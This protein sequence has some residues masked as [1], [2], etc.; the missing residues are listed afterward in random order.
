MS[1]LLWY[2]FVY[3]KSMKQGALGPLEW[4]SSFFDVFPTEKL[5]S[6]TFITE[7]KNEYCF[8]YTK[9]ITQIVPILFLEPFSGS[10]AA[11]VAQAAQACGWMH[12]C[13]ADGSIFILQPPVSSTC[14]RWRLE[15]SAQTRHC[16]E[17]LTSYV[18]LLLQRG[19]T[20]TPQSSRGSSSSSGKEKKEKHKS[21]QEHQN[22][23]SPNPLINLSPPPPS[24]P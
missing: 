20:V 3:L 1:L 12:L 24:P 5:G 2:V 14:L 13:L 11:A 19:S 4:F 8:I 22:A 17:N 9:P 18:R 15:K 7:K 16:R 6:K 23:H 10:Q 21:C